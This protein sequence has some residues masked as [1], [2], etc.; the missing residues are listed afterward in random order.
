MLPPDAL[1][2]RKRPPKPRR[3]PNVIEPHEVA[4][5]IARIRIELRPSDASIACARAQYLDATGRE[6]DETRRPGFYH[7]PKRNQDPDNEAKYGMLLSWSVF[8]YSATGKL[9][10]EERGFR[11]DKA[12]MWLRRGYDIGDNAIH[13]EDRLYPHPVTA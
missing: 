4:P 5:E 6:L 1:A 8:Y 3:N 7:C 2:P 12:L 9:L 11:R 13:E 10:H